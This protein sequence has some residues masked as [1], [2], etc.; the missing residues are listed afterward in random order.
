M[1]RPKNKQRL[2]LL[3]LFEVHDPPAPDEEYERRMREES[4]WRTEGHVVTALK[5]L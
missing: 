2:R 1:K 4:D 3:V 5:A